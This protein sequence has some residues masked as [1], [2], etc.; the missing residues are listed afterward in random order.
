MDKCYQQT[1]EDGIRSFTS[2]VSVIAFQTGVH[3]ARAVASVSQ[4]VWPVRL[5][6]NVGRRIRTERERKVSRCW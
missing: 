2:A 5:F 3:L 6:R 4:L 1:S